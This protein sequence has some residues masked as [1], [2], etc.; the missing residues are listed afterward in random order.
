MEISASK[1]KELREL[2]NAGVMD[3]RKALIQANGDTQRAV[4]I[5]REMGASAAAK[6]SHRSTEQGIID[7]YIHHNGRVGAM[8]ELLSE[9]DF[10][11]TRPEFKQ[12][13][14]DIALQVV[15][16][17]PKYLNADEVPADYEGNREEAA[18][19]TQPF[20]RDP[21]TTVQ[22]MIQN[23]IATTGEN[24]RLR[25]FVRLEV[26]EELEAGN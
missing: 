11:S 19:L 20:F 5:L 14:H 18:L 16:T 22:K 26:G 4:E 21:G 23:M 10:V 17:N 1:V 6:K 8:V 15:A 12:L 3:C 13:A 7:A 25:R 9:T 2:T 24:I